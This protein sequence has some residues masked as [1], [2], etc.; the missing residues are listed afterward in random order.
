MF[1]DTTQ[2]CTGDTADLVRLLRLSPMP[3]QTRTHTIASVRDL[4][5]AMDVDGEVR[6]PDLAQVLADPEALGDR[7]G[8]RKSQILSDVRRALRHWDNAPRRRLALRLGIRLP[9]LDDAKEAAR[10]L[11]PGDKAKRAC[12]AID[13]FASYQGTSPG[14]I[15]ATAVAVETALRAAAPEDLGVAA[16]KSL[17]NKRALIRAAVKLVDPVAVSGREADLGPL[18]RDWRETVDLLVWMTP[19]HAKAERAVHRRLAV[20]ADRAGHGPGEVT[21]DFFEEFG[22]RELLTHATSHGEKL[23]GAARLW[24][25]ARDAGLLV[26]EAWPVELDRRRLPDV[27]WGQVPAGI[28]APFDAMIAGAASPQA[29]LSWS[30]AIPGEDE[31]DELG[32]AALTAEDVPSETILFREKGT[33]RNWQDAVKRTWHASLHDGRVTRKPETLAELFRKDCLL[34]VVRAIRNARRARCEAQAETWEENVRGRYECSLVQ[35]LV[36]VGRAH[37]LEDSAL[38]PAVDLTY[39][40]DPSIV[41]TKRLPDGTVKHVYEARRIGPRHARML[42]QFNEAS[43]LGRWFEVPETLWA[44]A[45]KPLRLGRSPQPRH[46]ALARSAILARLSQRVAP[47]R[48]ENLA[49]LRIGGETP[50][51]RLPVG[52]GHGWLILPARELKNLRSITVRI[53]PETVEMLRSWRKH[54]RP[55]ALAR[56]GSDADNPHLWPGAE[57]VRPELGKT[58]RYADGHGYITLNAMSR[59]FGHHMRRWAR[60]DMDLH[61]MRHIAG[62]VILDQ[63]PSAMALV[64]EILGHKKIETTQAYYAEVNGLVAQRRYLELL[65]Q[66]T[67]RA[68]GTLTFTFDDP[69]EE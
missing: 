19:H 53:D 13:A 60:L 21:G 35:A 44:K 33:L 5:S 43:A 1:D 34:A 28:R 37:E 40:L 69:K 9:D 42:R 47:L 54:F 14:R 15:T 56:A 55:V 26:A 18:R 22:E 38:Q 65:D 10:A 64:Q 41:G 31:E 67:R 52:R 57:T 49:R 61:V 45:C 63:D 36:A 7:L 25:S 32:L 68:L 6:V 20:C 4:R 48:R 66:A 2:C 12:D 11:F 39:K 3:A 58:G 59:A 30:D 24:N 46:I 23:R 62:K 8:E 50:H 51:I 29:D 27:A 16:V 17:E